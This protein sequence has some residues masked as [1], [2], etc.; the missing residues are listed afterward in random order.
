V[1][2]NTLLTEVSAQFGA[3]RAEYFEGDALYDHFTEPTYWPELRTPQP[4]FLVGGR[5]TGKTTVLRGLSYEGQSRLEGRDVSKWNHVGLYW[6]IDT[7]VVSAFSGGRTDELQWSRIFGHYLNLSLVGQFVDFLVWAERQRDF[8]FN[9]SAID[10]E[11]TALALQF[12]EPPGDLSTFKAQLRQRLI[13]FEAD[14]NNIDDGELPRL[15]V[16]GRPVKEL[17]QSA[18]SQGTLRGKSVYFM[19]DEFENL[20]NSQQRC[21]NTL[22]KHSGDAPFTFKIGV[23]ETGHREVAVANSLETL[24][25]PSD[26]VTINISERLKD[27]GFAD[28]A[29]R[30]C[31]QRLRRITRLDGTIVDLFPGVSAE[32][33][34]IILGAERVRLQI[35]GGLATPTDI[36]YFDRLTPLQASFIGYWA[37]SRTRSVESVVREFANDPKLWRPR[38]NN[39]QHAM[40]FTLRRG[41]AGQKK[42]YA[43]WET[44]VALAEGN[45]R[46]LLQMV[47]EAL[48]RHLAEG[49]ELSS[50]V[51]PQTQTAAAQEI[52]LRVLRQLPGMAA[53]GAQLARLVLG[54]G[55]VF[56]VMASQPEGHAPEVNQFRTEANPT[57]EVRELLD[58]AVMHL[59]LVRFA[60]DKRAANSGET[61]D[62]NYLLH[63]IFAPYFVF[64]HRRKRRI[65]ISSGDV[66]ELVKSPNRAIER[67][68]ARNNRRD[69]DEPLP[70]QLDL[71]EDFYRVAT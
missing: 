55:R 7:N 15:S 42:I 58:A 50:A 43:G 12:D 64:S 6:R 38:L 46:Y 23:K 26:F 20:S 11:T 62:W 61:S 2:L 25:E 4:C 45:I 51:T 35:R 41:V 16:Q 63:P 66:L 13:A 59:A 14:V 57:P 27:Q 18:I 60:G 10:L 32:E 68:L 67:I 1:S 24:I 47:G 44:F 49:N 48:T 31:T 17:V 3:A 19:L 70:E 37:H 29:E 40:L 5:G 33:E 28:F 8:D 21:V 39:H 65:S 71:F 56:Q 54:L 69:S 53:Q 9:A 52:G 36:A 30:V 34:A 22:I